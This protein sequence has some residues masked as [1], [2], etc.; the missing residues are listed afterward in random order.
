MKER[1]ARLRL[2]GVDW[3]VLLS[4]NRAQSIFRGYRNYFGI[5]IV[6]ASTY[7]RESIA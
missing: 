5:A 4:P 6:R 7:E 3:I 1:L 2:K